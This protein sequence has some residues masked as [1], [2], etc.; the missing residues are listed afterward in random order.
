MSK[1]INEIKDIPQNASICIYGT[2]RRGKAFQEYLSKYRTDV[3]INAFLDTF[4]YNGTLNNIPI[5]NIELLMQNSINYDFIV[6]ASS[7]WQEIL[8]LLEKNNIFNYKILSFH[9]AT[10]LEGKIIPKKLYLEE[11]QHNFKE[12][13]V[14]IDFI[15]KKLDDE[16]DKK[17]YQFLYNIRV[18]ENN[19]EELYQKMQN[20]EINS[21][22]YLQYLDFINRK[23]IKTLID[24]G[25]YDAAGIDLFLRY[26]PNLNKI[27]GYEPL[28]DKFCPYIEKLFLEENLK[29][30]EIIPKAVFSEEKEI[31]IS[32]KLHSSSIVHNNNRNYSI[33]KTTVLDKLLENNIS[34]IDFIKLDIEDA[35][36]EA[37]KGAEKLLISHRPQIAVCIY[38]SF[39]QFIKVPQYLMEI[40]PDYTF[41]LTHYSYN[42]AETVLFAIP[43]E[44]FQKA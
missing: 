22:I 41:K 11:F 43:K 20:N 36:L 7:F 23:E 32:N 24:C 35:E 13:K 18:G 29:K 17:L 6:L 40:L 31:S 44:I 39:E 42:L 19:I 9:L 37:L 10:C 33:I 38:H 1:Y 25:V 2:G 26:L 15:L 28:I 5:F 34:K 12:K 30:I 14:P 16:N 27:Y 21:H 8:T 3:K 4:E